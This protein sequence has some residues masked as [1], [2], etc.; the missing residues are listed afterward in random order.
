MTMKGTS[1]FKS[2][3]TYCTLITLCVRKSVVLYSH[4]NVKVSGGW[5]YFSAKHTIT[6]WWICNIMLGHLVIAECCWTVI[7][8]LAYVTLQSFSSVCG[9]MLFDVASAVCTV[10]TE[11]T[12]IHTLCLCRIELVKP[13]SGNKA[14]LHVKM[15]RVLLKSVN[16]TY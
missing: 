2:S 4:V 8:Q 7:F 11:Y 13:C 14:F 3:A 6:A 9:H 10:F 16:M 5:K 15:I 1:T 12:F